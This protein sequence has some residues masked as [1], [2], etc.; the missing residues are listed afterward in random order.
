MLFLNRRSIQSFIKTTTTHCLI[1]EDIT[2]DDSIIY[3]VDLILYI[4]VELDRPYKPHVNSVQHCYVNG[5]WIYRASKDDADVMRMIQNYKQKLS[6]VRVY[7]LKANSSRRIEHF[8]Y[9]SGNDR[10]IGI[11]VDASL[12]WVVSCSLEFNEDDLILAFNLG[13]DRFSVVP[14][15]F[16]N[17]FVHIQLGVPGRMN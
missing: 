8:T 17:K 7:S 1:V 14:F 9:Y 11:L 4:I 12:H 13:D 15:P 5:N 16:L 10:E 3:A 6:R 2:P